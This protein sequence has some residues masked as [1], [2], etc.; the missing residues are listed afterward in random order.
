MRRR[1]AVVGAGPC[2]IAALKA[3]LAEGHEAVAFEQTGRIGGN[4]VF[5]PEPSHSS[6]CETTHIISSRRWS[7]YEDFPM[8]AHYPDYPSHAQVL[9][10][11]EAYA[12]HFGLAP[13]IRLRVRVER[14]ERDAGGG[15]TLHLGGE[16]GAGSERFDAL[17]VAN[18]HHWDPFI[19]EVAGR[20]DGEVM[21]SHSFKRAEP[22]RGLRV[23]VVGAGNSACDVAVESCRVAGFV[24]LSVRRGQHIVP[25]FLRGRPADDNH[26]GLRWIPGVLR[27]RL[28]AAGLR[29]VQGSYADY[30]LPEPDVGLLE[31]HPTVNSELLY[32][33][34]HG[35]IHPRPAVACFD[36][37]DVVFTDGRREPYDR[38]LFATGYNIRFPFLDPSLV[39][40]VDADTIPLYRKMIPDGVEDLYF[41][42]LFQPLGCIWPLADLQARI[43]ARA[44][45]G[46]WRRPSDLGSRIAREQAQPHY[47]FQ[48]SRR[49]AVEVDYHRFRAELLAELG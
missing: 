38:V 5:R 4:W 41:I 49:H 29:L 45:S 36:G 37:A 19:P 18:G 34:R 2:G 24:G 16:S 40:W 23:L 10:Y 14:A 43:A 42:G 7:S 46:R 35:R 13:H 12:Q 44:L 25:K 26:A 33:I 32:F 20:F 3:L 30:G 6:V 48:R 11:F 1:V 47:R 31:M 9:A 28:L 27:Q 15:W 21:H 22:F 8:P 17:L 39:P